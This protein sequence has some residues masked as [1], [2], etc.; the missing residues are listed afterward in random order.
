MKH[1]LLILIV[2]IS[3]ISF[4]KTDNHAI[5]VSIAEVDY[6]SKQREIQVALKIFT[7]DLEMGIRKESK[8]VNLDTPKEIKDSDFY[9]KKY[10]KS[11]F[12]IKTNDKQVL[13][14]SYAGKEYIDDATWIYFSYKETPK[15][16][17]KITI[18]NSVITELHRQQKN[19]THF[20]KNRILIKSK[21]LTK[22]RSTVTINLK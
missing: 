8:H 9:I 1:L 11:R 3:T 6:F 10:L 15:K 21:H 17:K 7:D 20:K 2:A 12:T 14:I 5:Y 4:T 13:K 18:K 16:I 19:L 22:K